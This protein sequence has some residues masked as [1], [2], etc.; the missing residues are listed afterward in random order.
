MCGKAF[1]AILFAIA[2]IVLLAAIIE[3]Y[4]CSKSSRRD[5]FAATPEAEKLQSAALKW[6]SNPESP[7]SYTAFANHIRSFYPNCDAA[8]YH[9]LKGLYRQKQ[10]FSTDDVQNIL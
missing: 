10:D 1:A 9:K 2:L 7:D 4:N 3:L 6:F 5:G 8:H